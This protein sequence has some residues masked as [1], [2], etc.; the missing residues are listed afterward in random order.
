MLIAE[1]SLRPSPPDSCLHGAEMM[2]GLYQS[3]GES[4]LQISGTSLYVV[5]GQLIL[6]LCTCCSTA[7]ACESL[8]TQYKA[9]QLQKPCV[10]VVLVQSAGKGVTPVEAGKCLQVWRGIQQTLKRLAN[11]QAAR[12]AAVFSR[13]SLQPTVVAT[14]GGL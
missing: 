7:T 13:E 12:Q 6:G 8:N 1:A 11:C 2:V 4:H 3:R 14:A 9:V 10:D 5:T